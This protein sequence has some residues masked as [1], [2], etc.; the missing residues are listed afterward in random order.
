MVAGHRGAA[1]KAR[2][3]GLEIR[4]PDLGFENAGRRLP[5]KKVWDTLPKDPLRCEI[6]LTPIAAE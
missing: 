4:L 5:L 1:A 3:S 2:G 6:P